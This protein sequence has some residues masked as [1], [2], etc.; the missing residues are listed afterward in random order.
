MTARRCFKDGTYPFHLSNEEKLAFDAFMLKYVIDDA[1]I[2]QGTR[3]YSIDELFYQKKPNLSK[4]E[5]KMKTSNRKIHKTWEVV[6]ALNKQ[7]DRIGH[8]F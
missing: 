2:Q 7:T 4:F 6:G 8:K 1:Y 5:H 3:L